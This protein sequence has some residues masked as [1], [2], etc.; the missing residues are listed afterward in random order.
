L[1]GLGEGDGFDGGGQVD[2]RIV[3]GGQRHE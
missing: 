3:R 1:I 2:F